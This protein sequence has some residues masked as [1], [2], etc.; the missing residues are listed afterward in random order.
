MSV[1]ESC[2]NSTEVVPVNCE[3]SETEKVESN[4]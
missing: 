4:N 1:E 2:E 3:T